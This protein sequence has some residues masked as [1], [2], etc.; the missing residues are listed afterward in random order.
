MQAQ[1]IHVHVS[2]GKVN[3]ILSKRQRVRCN[4]LRR[5]DDWICPTCESL[6]IQLNLF[7]R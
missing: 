5:L 3:S 6:T 2:T 7:P 1:R 4:F